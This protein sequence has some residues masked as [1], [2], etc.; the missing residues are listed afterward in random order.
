MFSKSSLGYNLAVINYCEVQDHNDR[1]VSEGGS[2]GQYLGSDEADEAI[3]KQNL[4]K[5]EKIKAEKK[6]KTELDR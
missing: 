4:E 6:A 2:L 3:S 5:V 1:I